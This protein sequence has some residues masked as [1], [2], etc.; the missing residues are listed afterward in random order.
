M[1]PNP[2]SEHDDIVWGDEDKI[3]IVTV[4]R[5]V[6]G[7]EAAARLLAAYGGVT[8]FVPR[9]VPRDHELSRVIGWSAARSIAAEIGGQRSYVH[10]G[11][12]M[13]VAILERAILWAKLAGMKVRKIALL[14]DR[15]DRHVRHISSGLR[16]LGR[17]PEQMPRN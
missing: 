16:Q 6:A 17:L 3:C 12:Q 5:R 2:S 11:G 9:N 1:L 4:A 10:A 15:S 8:I 13:Q 7:E 14:V